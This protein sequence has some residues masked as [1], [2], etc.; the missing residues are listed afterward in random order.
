MIDYHGDDEI[1]HLIRDFYQKDG[2][3]IFYKELA[4]GVK[5]FKK[6]KEEREL[7]VKQ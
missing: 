3:D 5:P 4:D 1:G 7:C 2:K 6:N